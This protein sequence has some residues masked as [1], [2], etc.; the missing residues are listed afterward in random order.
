MGR[1]VVIGGTFAGIAA[2]VRLARVGHAVV[3]VD[4]DA[5]FGDSLRTALG[6]SIDFPAPWR[7]LLKKSGRPAAGALGALGLQLVPDDGD[8]FPTERGEQYRHIS[9]TLGEPWAARWR[10]LVDHYADVWQALRPLGVEA[11]LD[12]DAARQASPLLEP[13]V[14]VADAAA[15][16]G[17]PV[18]S[19]RVLAVATDR[20][21]DPARTPAWLLSRLAIERTFGRWRLTDLA[22]R[23][24]PG[25][26]L[27]D[28]VVHRLTERDVRV[29]TARVRDASGTRVATDAGAV[30]ADAVIDTRDPH[31][32]WRGPRRFPPRTFLDDLLARPPLRD[33][34]DPRLFRASASSAAGPEPWAQL[35]TG[36]LATYAAHEA[37]TGH[38]IRPTSTGHA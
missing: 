33:P 36:A 22:G 30:D 23:P 8:G 13:R 6:D 2:A 31:A 4:A 38:D 11:E 16:L 34:R 1:V 28:V 18:L 14:S 26:R 32:P 25:G 21:L 10:D 35:L 17:H 24:L 7:D 37:L 29:L 20:G 15:R 27:V 3:L 12:P 5:A 19:G 9:A